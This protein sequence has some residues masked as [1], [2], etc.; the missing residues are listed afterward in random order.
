MNLAAGLSN[1][2]VSAT[3]GDHTDNPRYQLPSKPEAAYGGKRL[4]STARPTLSPRQSSKTSKICARCGTAIHQGSLKALGKYFHEECFV[5]FD[6]GDTCRPKYFPFEDPKTHQLI[7]LCQQD[8]FKRN[9]LLC[10]V[11]DKPLRG[12]YYNAFGKLYDEEHFCC[13]I[14]HEKCGINT[15]FNYNDDLYC[16]YHFLKL[17]SHR[18]KGCNYPISDQY[19]EFPRGDEVHRWHPECYGIHKYWHVNIPPE[20]VGLPRLKEYKENTDPKSFEKLHPSRQELEKQ[21]NSFGNLIAKTWSVLYKFEEEAAVCISDMFQYLTSLDQLKGLHSAALLVLKT[22]CLFR[23]LDSLNSLTNFDMKTPNSSLTA[24]DPNHV[25][26]DVPIE[27]ESAAYK[28]A[29]LPRN[30]STKLMIYLQLLRKLSAAPSDKDVNVSSLMSVIT[31]LAHF[32]KLLVRHG[33]QTALERNRSVHTANALIKFLRDIEHNEAFVDKPFDHVDVSIDATDCCAHCRKYI[34]EACLQFRTYRW[35]KNCLGCSSCQAPIDM[36]GV[37]D[38]AFD[39]REEKVF[40]AQC[41]V[42][43]P[44]SSPGF[45]PVTKL[46]QLIFLLKIALI[47]S[48]AVMEIQLKNKD[49]LN[50]SNSVKESISMQQTYI[51]TLNDIKRLKSRRQSVPLSSNKR[52]ARRS[53]IIETSEMDL[54]DEESA[55]EKSLII[56][57]ERINLPKEGQNMFN[58]TKTLTLDDI[59]RIVAAEQA[60]ELRPNAFT[61]FKKLKDNDDEVVGIVNKKGGI[62]FSELQPREMYIVRLLALALLGAEP[63]SPLSKFPSQ[64]QKLIPQPP[65]EPKQPSGTFWSRMKIMMSK[66]TKRASCQKVF[67]SSLDLLSNEWGTESDLGI[68][69]SKIKIPIIIDELISSLRQM[70]MSV[71]GIF[72]KNGNIRK[73]RELA[74]AIDSNPSEV[75]DLSKENAVQLSALLKKFLRDL[76]DPLLTFPLYDIWIEVA[77][78][79]SDFEK[80]KYYNLLY[81]LLPTSHRNLAEVLF[82][83]LHWTSSF[84]HIDSQMGSKMDIHNLSTVITPNILYHLGNTSTQPTVNGGAIHNTYKDAFAQNEGENYFLAIEVVNYL[85]NHNEDMSIVPKFMMNLL[86]G[87]QEKNLYD[88]ESLK[89]FALAHVKE[90]KVTF[91]EYKVGESVTMK[92]STSVAR[93]EIKGKERIGMD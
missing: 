36:Y 68:G 10:H 51:R 48:K 78:I 31:G 35:H 2:H 52:E 47:R 89:Q 30:F 57:T 50:R 15:C 92:N 4:V 22:E 75:P 11:C 60:R 70:D 81:A 21:V 13:K 27:M 59:S 6:C 28:Y 38:A 66:D 53:K 7:P 73:L 45:K 16:K 3:H 32:L 34:Q 54:I 1:A 43:N 65:K 40:C 64:V 71:E 44:E 17:F 14:C 63:N 76:P 80:H 20:A 72:R 86:K 42:R 12:V 37:A 77:K 93:I 24:N 8:Y 90:G 84:S 9:N 74:N 61:Y 67:G 62:Y 49:A 55:K 58:S 41:A 56:Q 23:G 88:P 91:S 33:L 46:A 87:A 82:S 39:L 19:I 29:K 79:D 18:C 83:F 85:I 5:C 69:P 25:L 26:L